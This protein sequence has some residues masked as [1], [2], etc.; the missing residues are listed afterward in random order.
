[1]TQRIGTL[2]AADRAGITYRQIDYWIRCGYI[3][4]DQGGSGSRTELDE[5]ELGVLLHI[6]LLIRA[7]LTLRVAHD[8]AR[9][10]TTEGSEYALGHGVVIAIR[11][12]P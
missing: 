2:E 11:E 8:A 6:G 12:M 3:R 9:Y 1:M 7:G 5:T 10:L 4:A